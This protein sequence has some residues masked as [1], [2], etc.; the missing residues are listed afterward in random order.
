MRKLDLSLTPF[1]QM[2]RGTSPRVGWLRKYFET[3]VVN[4]FNNY[5]IKRNAPAVDWLACANTDCVA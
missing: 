3:L 5:P 2:P 4:I 1:A